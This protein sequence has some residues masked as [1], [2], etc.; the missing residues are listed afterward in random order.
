MPAGS[1]GALPVRRRARAGLLVAG[2]VLL[3][4]LVTVAPASAAVSVSR[5]ELSG[6]TLRLE[7]T[8]TAS[9]D[10]T[11]DGVVMGRSDSGGR[12]RIDR[13]GYTAPADCTVDVNDG[14]ATPRVA[15]LSGCTV[16]PPAAPAAGPAAPTLLAPANGASVTTPVTL[17]WSA[18]LD[19]NPPSFNGGHNW[20]ISSSSTFAIAGHGR[21]D[22]A[23][24]HAGLVGGLVAGTYFWRVQA[25]DGALVISPWSADAQLHRHRTGRGALAA[26]VLAPLVVGARTTRW[27]TSRSPGAR[28]PG[29][30]IPRRGLP[31]RRLLPGGDPVRQYLR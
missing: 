28:C 24:R 7:G 27:R 13:S 16:N 25:V 10:I 15:T 26:P 17:S 1:S 12:F 6:T 9:R 22:L 2:L 20:E 31:Q 23:E 3:S 30:G 5:A 21:L 14:S 19:P 8:A 18:V 4:M 29:R 11:V